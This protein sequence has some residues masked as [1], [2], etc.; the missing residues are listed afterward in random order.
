MALLDQLKHE[1]GSRNVAKY[2]ANGE[3]NTVGDETLQGYLAEGLEKLAEFKPMPVSADSTMAGT[4]ELALPAS[5]WKPTAIFFQNRYLAEAKSFEVYPGDR[6]WDDQVVERLAL[7]ENA[8]YPDHRE[9]QL[10]G[11]WLFDIRRKVIQ[12]VEAISGSVKLFGY[13]LPTEDKLTVG[14]KRDILR[15]ALGTAL[16]NI[17]PSLMAKMDIQMEGVNVKQKT[18]EY[19]AEGQRL[20]REFEQN[21]HSPYISSG[22]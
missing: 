12:F 17:T 7:N 22:R 11:E 10:Y 6:L 8:E 14:D 13:G 21:R 1:L 19:A 20:L 4:M 2:Y 5:I 9:T 15:Y 16:V 3:G 18:D